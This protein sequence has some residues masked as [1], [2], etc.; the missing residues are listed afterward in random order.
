[1]AAKVTAPYSTPERLAYWYL[2]LNGF[3]VLDN[4]II[5]PD[6]GSEQRTDVDLFGVRFRDRAELLINPMED[7]RRWTTGGTYVSVI[8]A[9]VKRS[10]CSLNG[11]WTKPER[12]NMQRVLRAIG[13]LPD[14]T[15]EPAAEALYR[16]GSFS[17]NLCT[18]SLI[19]IGASKGKLA[20][21]TV[22]QVLFEDMIEFIHG[23]FQAY[24]RQ[25]ASVGNWSQDGQG[26]ASAARNQSY[27][28]FETWVKVHF[29]LP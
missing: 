15:V 14:S 26:L 10:K 9:E 1:M 2:R 13:C 7:D 17:D 12:Q 24:K 3:F 25:K 20:I 16:T 5:H 8:I 28:I 29:C 6:T 21:D 18:C 27:E 11:P 19:A 22:P 4:F 23:R